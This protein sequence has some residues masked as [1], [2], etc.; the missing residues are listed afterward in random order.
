[1]RDLKEALEHS[2]RFGE[3]IGESAPMQAMFELL[4]R[5]APSE[6]TVLI[7]GETGCGKELVARALHDMSPRSEGPF[8]ALNCAAVPENLLESELFGHRKGAF[9]D[10]HSD[11]QGL[12]VKANKGTLYLD[13]V[14][15]MPLSVQPKLLRVL[16]ER[17]LRPIGSDME[18]SFDT[19]IVAATN[20][21]LYAEVEDGRFRRDLYFRVN[22]VN[23]AVPPLRAR[24]NDILLL[25]QHFIEGF[26]QQS[27]GRQIT[28]SK[29]V[30]DRLLTYPWPGNVRELRNAM[31]RAVT[32]TPDDELRC[33][34]LPPVIV[35][36]RDAAP[37]IVPSDPGIILPLAEV[38]KKYIQHILNRTG[39]N[40]TEAA[41]LLQMDRKT[42]H[43][44]LDGVDSKK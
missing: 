26:A 24:G 8:V 10:A 40:K 17:V 11:R 28:M 38:E 1:V 35:N 16:E 22:V 3:I 20:R 29:A 36:Y 7:T 42:L 25:A 19:R 30:V 18:I 9:T 39:G 21:D 15:E 33:E 23:I 2:G 44:K 12:F 5:L 41:R 34:V 6:V 31:E 37:A 27:H 4:T 43:R 32:L 13:E 14:G